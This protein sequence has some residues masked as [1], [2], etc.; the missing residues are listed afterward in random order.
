[1]QEADAEDVTQTVLLEVARQMNTFVYDPA[2]SFRT[3]LKTIAPRAGIKLIEA[4]RL[5][6]GASGHRGTAAARRRGGGPPG[7]R[8]AA[9]V[10]P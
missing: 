4:R 1:L 5:P 2:G 8:V 7:G 6:V 10:D 3:W 9:L